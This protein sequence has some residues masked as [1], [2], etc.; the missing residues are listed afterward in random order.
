LEGVS[1][2]ALNRAAVQGLMCQLGPRVSLVAAEQRPAK[3]SALAEARVF[4]DS[5][6]YFRVASVTSNL[7]DA[8]VSAYK[9]MVETNKSKIKG[10][11]LDLRFADGLDYA[12]AAK[13]ADCF[14]S[15]EH[16][17]LDWQTGSAHATLKADAITIPVAILVNSQTAGAAEALAAVLRDTEVGLILGSQTAGQASIFKEFPLHDGDKL[18]VAVAQI[19]FGAGKTLPHGL[20]PDIAVTS[21]LDDERAYLQDPSKV[22]RPPAITKTDAAAQEVPDQPR[23]NEA[24][25]IREH[26]SGEDRYEAP[27]RS[28]VDVPE[29]APLVADPALARALDLLKGL[30]VVQPNRPG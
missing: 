6:A 26:S 30:A 16:A 17:L 28:T 22:L 10:L 18:R 11:V 3:I 20:T 21:S 19:S 4:D 23:L 15:S 13:L 5:F 8:F 12:A 29:S 27:V 24:E 9:Q 25:L 7:S 1:A 2:E 14:L